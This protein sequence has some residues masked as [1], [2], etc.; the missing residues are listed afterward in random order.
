MLVTTEIAG[1]ATLPVRPRPQEPGPPEATPEGVPAFEPGLL[2]DIALALVDVDTHRHDT[3]ALLRLTAARTRLAQAMLACSP[4]GFAAA[5]SGAVLSLH[6]RMVTMGLAQVP[7]EAADEGVLA[8]LRHFL[9][10]SLAPLEAPATL[11]VSM[12]Y[13]GPHLQQPRRF[14]DDEP[15][16]L[17]PVY[18]KYLFGP[19]ASFRLPNE[20][21][22]YARHMTA[23][24]R[25]IVQGLD[26]GRQAAHWLGVALDFVNQSSM[27]PL[28]F[29]ESA[30]HEVMGLRARVI[31]TLLGQL[32]GSPGL[33]HTFA[34]R[35]PG[36]RV[37][38]GV[39]AAHFRPQTETYATLPVYAGLDRG[40]FEVVLISCL[41]V[42]DSPLEQHCRSFADSVVDLS[43]DTVTDVERIRAL[44]LD[45]IW[46]GTNVTATLNSVVQ[47]SAHRLARLQMT[48]GCSPV[49]SGLRHIDVFV[50]GKGTEVE[51]AATHYT[52][53]L[54]LLPGPA[55]CFDMATSVAA[56]HTGGATVAR[57]SL[58]LPEGVPV[59]VSGANF[60]KIVPELLDAWVDILARTPGSRLLLFPFN[61]NWTSRYP[62]ANF[63]LQVR[64][65]AA[66]RGVK[67]E[68]IVIV[69]PLPNRDGVLALLR[70][71]DVYLD[72]FPYSGMTS[73]LDPLEVG[74]PIVAT[75]GLYQRQRMAASA[76]HALGLADWLTEGTG[77]Y[78]ER[79]VQLALEPARRD[80][81][82][83]AL[84]RAMATAPRFLDAAWYSSALADIIADEIA[85]RAGPAGAP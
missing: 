18:R 78:V 21:D 66:S 64:Q 71:A 65:R 51:D 48:G 67:A 31:E 43:G 36:R 38:L 84:A 46:I 4:A 27:I 10:G 29:A 73:L 45:A 26:S 81:M 68:R 53:R 63:T 57:S 5:W 17:G 32:Q 61:P 59:F 79:A 52:E 24:L 77:G 62:V 20:A 13:I 50:S 34:P 54:R 56:S 82:R 9:Q 75:Q 42:G 30:L 7:A 58:G 2:S 23:L 37:R 25:E 6:E 39:L 83:A 35:L 85:S 76:L 3:D 33:D 47:L 69:P 72:S 15:V 49:T 8:R 11:A 80:A 60:F 55:H 14:L 19:P 40:R 70:V 1:Q 28:Y 12:L 22:L 41:A 44:D 74:L 16:A